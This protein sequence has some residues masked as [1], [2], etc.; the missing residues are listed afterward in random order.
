MGSQR[1]EWHEVET[2]EQLDELLE[3]VG[4]FHDGI[5]KE[6]HWVNLAYIGDDLGMR[7]CQGSCARLVIQRQYR[8]PSA[9]ELHIEGM[10]HFDIDARD[11]VFGSQ[12]CEREGFLCLSIETCRFVFARLRYRFASDWMGPSMRLATWSF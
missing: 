10:Q 7:V 11:F 4:G 8:N 1:D 3:L 2:V 5:L 12:A 9:V 6:L